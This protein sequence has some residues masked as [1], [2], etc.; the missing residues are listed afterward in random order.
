VDPAGISR[1]MGVVSLRQPGEAA[2]PIVVDTPAADQRWLE[3]VAGVFSIPASAALPIGESGSLISEL[4]PSDGVLDEPIRDERFVVQLVGLTPERDIPA[5]AHLYRA[6]IDG[7]PWQSLRH[8]T[9]FEI[10]G[11]ADG[12]HLLE[13]V[14][15][16]HHLA[17]DPTPAQLRFVVDRPVPYWLW[18]TIV[19]LVGLVGTWQRRHLRWAFLRMLHL[20][21]RPFDPSLFDQTGP[22]D[23]PLDL[24]GR[25][26]LLHQL[27]S[28][29]SRARH[30]GVSM[31][32]VGAPRVGLTSVLRCLQVSNDTIVVDVDLAGRL[33]PASVL[34]TLADSIGAAFEEADLDL[35]TEAEPSLGLPSAIVSGW[36]DVMSSPFQRFESVIARAATA[37][38]DGTL[39][40]RIDHGESLVRISEQDPTL[41]ASVV[42][43]LKRWVTDQP[44]VALVT[45]VSGYIV[46]VEHHLYELLQVSSLH[47]VSSLALADV[48]DWLSGC[49]SH[50]VLFAPEH[51]EEVYRWAG[52]HPVIVR[53]FASRVATRLAKAR[54]NL[55]S[56]GDLDGA[57]QDL[58]AGSEPTFRA[59]WVATPRKARLILALLAEHTGGLSLDELIENAH[60]KQAPVVE[61][62]LRRIV[63][64]LLKD[65]RLEIHDG[66]LTIAVGLFQT[67]IAENSPIDEALEESREVVGPYQILGILGMGGMGVVY[68]ARDPNRGAQCAVKVM[69]RHLLTDV[70]AQ[71][72][73]QREADH[74]MTLDHPNIVKILGRGRYKGQSYLVVELVEGNTLRDQ[75]RAHGAMPWRE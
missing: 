29:I 30:H 20:R 69:A 66:R 46:D 32:L 1:E 55:V 61:V 22:I 50:A 56:I 11:L 60:S 74:G 6:R 31:V 33:T 9:S 14:A 47:Q 7:G 64:S 54:R 52:G 68:R 67:W 59:F 42:V 28:T 27:E 24:V 25:S 75:I 73:F 65:G 21:F 71:R 44:R 4:P 18:G 48:G 72:R 45:A 15:K 5:D 39:L 63:D 49:G 35:D 62:E 58:Q 10:S 8:K 51:V 17:R 40:V 34:V 19:V 38:G 26:P 16:G 12:T 70:D 36:D 37:L 2:L 23:N 3:S 41:G 53:R 57:L 13:V 43:A